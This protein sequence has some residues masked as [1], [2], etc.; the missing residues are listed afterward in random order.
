MFKKKYIQLNYK[1]KSYLCVKTFVLSLV[2]L[3]YEYRHAQTKMQVAL[4]IVRS[5]GLVSLTFSY[6]RK[7]L[8]GQ[9]SVTCC[10]LS[11]GLFGNNAFWKC[12]W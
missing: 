8:I 3:F 9:C 5:F 2:F 12:P 10:P 6:P 7:V 11:L 1:M 4:G